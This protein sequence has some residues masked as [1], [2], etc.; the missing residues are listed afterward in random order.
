M[1][2]NVVMISNATITIS[3]NNLVSGNARISTSTKGRNPLLVFN[4]SVDL[5]FCNY[6]KN[7]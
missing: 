7:Y 4:P 1:A 6:E 3:R 2:P 5:F